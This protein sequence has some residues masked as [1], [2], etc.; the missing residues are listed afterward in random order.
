MDIRHHLLELTYRAP[1]DLPNAFEQRDRDILFGLVGKGARDVRPA[2][3]QRY[4]PDVVERSALADVRSLG[5]LAC[6]QVT[7]LPMS[8]VAAVA[9]L[10]VNR[11]GSRWKSQ[12]VL[13]ARDALRAMNGQGVTVGKVDATRGVGQIGPLHDA[14]SAGSCAQRQSLGRGIDHLEN[15]AIAT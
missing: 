7:D 11:L 1:P 4:L 15:T 12:Y 6:Q 13:P 2:V 10:A 5:R 9:G 8:R 14:C 3:V